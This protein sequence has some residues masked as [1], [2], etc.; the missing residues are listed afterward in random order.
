DLH[1]GNIALI[2]DRVTIFDC[3]EFNEELRW[4]DVMSEIA[5]LV[6]DLQAR[7]RADL[8]W[9]LLNAY[10]EATGD[11]RGLALLRFYL[12]Y[13]AMVRAKRA[14]LNS[15]QS[16]ASG[17]AVAGLGEEAHYLSLATSYSRASMPALLITHGLAGSG[18]ST[19]SLPLLAL[20]G[21][22]RIRTD[23]ERK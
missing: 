9:R 18:K 20:I 7:A 2:D 6:M 13:R 16:A 19:L 3:I 17:G 8:S 14:W 10:L 4:I 23:V 11:Y 1:L 12:I 22:I 21:G 15:N 5:F